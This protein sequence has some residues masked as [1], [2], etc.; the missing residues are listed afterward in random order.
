MKLVR[1]SG[2]A[3]LIQQPDQRTRFGDSSAEERDDKRRKMSS[4]KVNSPIEM[5][6][7]DRVSRLADPFDSLDSPQISVPVVSAGEHGFDPYIQFQEHQ[8]EPFDLLQLDTPPP[9]KPQQA[10]LPVKP[11]IYH[12]TDLIAPTP[13]VGTPGGVVDDLFSPEFFADAPVPSRPGPL[14]DLQP[15]PREP[16]PNSRL[17]V[18]AANDLFPDLGNPKP[19][20]VPQMNARA[21]MAGGPRQVA[22]PRN[23][24]ADIYPF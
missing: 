6:G 7:S 16:P 1:L 19:V 18:K 4:Q 14:I 8:P 15:P 24:F 17:F 13:A 2:S 5:S 9:H 11:E 22:P 12:F 10:N 23:A 21:A 20:H 3:L